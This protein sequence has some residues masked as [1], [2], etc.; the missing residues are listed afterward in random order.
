MSTLHRG[1]IFHLTGTPAVQQ[2]VEA[3][4]EIP[5]GALLVDDDG[6][7]E[8]CGHHVDR[9]QRDGAPVEVVDHGDAFLLP[10]FV[11]THMHFPQVNSIDAYGGGQLLEWLTECIFPA[12]ARFEK[13]E[14]AIGAAREFCH[15]LISAGTTTSLVFG[16]AFP[17]AQDALFG[18]YQRRGL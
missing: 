12:E 1:H 4:V 16:S 18:E 17:A 15:R 6:V 13:E 10:G 14:F 3:L 11:D 5:D 2:A 8:W 7:I 9:P